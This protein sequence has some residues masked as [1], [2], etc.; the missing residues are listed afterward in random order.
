[1]KTGDLI[2]FSAK[3]GSSTI[4]HVEIFIGNNKF[5]QASSGEGLVTITSLSN[6]YYKERIVGVRRVFEN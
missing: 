2:F 6:N 4:S 5:I 1:M 3:I